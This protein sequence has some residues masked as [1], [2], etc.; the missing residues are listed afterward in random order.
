MNL[1]IFQAGQQFGPF[2]IEQVIQFFEEGRIRPNDQIWYPDLPTWISIASFFKAKSPSPEIQRQPL[3]NPQTSI[4]TLVAKR[5]QL[6]SIVSRLQHLVRSRD[7]QRYQNRF[8][9]IGGSSNE[10]TWFRQARTDI[11][12]ELKY[13]NLETLRQIA[14]YERQIAQLDVEIE[15]L[16]KRL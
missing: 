2:Y 6:Q 9:E 13:Q 11:S 5:A 3:A 16:L 10:S 12:T 4:E 15:R 8:D 7:E 1:Y 14:E